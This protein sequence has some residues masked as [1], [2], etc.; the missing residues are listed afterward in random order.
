ML[1]SVTVLAVTIFS[2]TLVRALWYAPQLNNLAPATTTL[3]R[4]VPPDEMPARLVIPKLEIDT[5]IQYVGVTAEGNMG[6]PNNFRDVAWYKYGPVPGERGSAV[7]AGHVDN[8][9][10]LAGVFKHLG[11]LEPG[12]DVYVERKNGERIHFVVVEREIYHYQE[13]PLDKLF[14]RTDGTYLNLVTCDGSWIKDER[15]YDER[16]VVYTRLVR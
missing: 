8:G 9:L 11:D 1:A 12:D 7:V 2:V 3:Q 10:S 16:L 6:V 13:V 4:V 5:D 15:T 14:E